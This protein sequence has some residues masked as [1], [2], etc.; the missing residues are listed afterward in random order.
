MS[1]QRKVFKFRMEPTTFQ[2]D[3]VLRMA[4]TAR[5]I[6]NWAVDRCQAFYKENNKRTPRD[7]WRTN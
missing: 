6:W 3:E 2:S 5:F 1:E 4:G 7:N